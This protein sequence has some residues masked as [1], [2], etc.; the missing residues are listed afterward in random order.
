MSDLQ[1]FTGQ[2][3][4]PA[5]ELALVEQ[6]EFLSR[7]SYSVFIATAAREDK[8]VQCSPWVNLPWAVSLRP[9][10]FGVNAAT[11]CQRMNV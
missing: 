9:A 10:P 6:R 11:C 5:F 4:Q 1:R 3:I 8:T 7:K 2:R